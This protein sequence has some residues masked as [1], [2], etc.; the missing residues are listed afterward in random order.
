MFRSGERYLKN[1]LRVMKRIDFDEFRNYSDY[2]SDRGEELNEE[3]GFYPHKT[4]ISELRQNGYGTLC[5]K[6]VFRRR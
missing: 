6:Q 2:L 3:L 4:S 1:S 5:G